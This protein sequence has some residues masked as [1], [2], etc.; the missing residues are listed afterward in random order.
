MTDDDTYEIEKILKKSKV[1][2][3]QGVLE[4]YYYIKWKGY[5]SSHNTWEPLWSLTGCGQTLRE[6]EMKNYRPDRSKFY[7]VQEAPCDRGKPKIPHRIAGYCDIPHGERMY[8]VYWKHRR[9]P[10]LVPASCPKYADFFSR[11]RVVES[12]RRE[13]TIP[14][15]PKIET[16]DQSCQT[17]KSRF[18][19]SLCPSSLHDHNYFFPME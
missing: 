8:L 5:D 19:C 4:C 12:V 11:Y 2:N 16:R 9:Q 15:R 7:N 3:E 17:P 6:F 14:K 1:P 10:D 18:G 13:V